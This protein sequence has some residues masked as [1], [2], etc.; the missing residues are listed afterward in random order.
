MLIIQITPENNE[1]IEELKSSLEYLL[2]LTKGVKSVKVLDGEGFSITKKIPIYDAEELKQ[3]A[4]EHMSPR[5][6]L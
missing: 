5:V 6:Q 2:S 3:L 1:N 4:K